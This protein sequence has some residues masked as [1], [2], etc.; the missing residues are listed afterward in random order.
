MRLCAALDTTPLIAILRRVT[1]AEAEAVGAALI[2]AGIL[3]IETPLNSPEPLRSIAV[4]ASRFGDVAA[5]GA[6]TVLNAAQVAQIADAGA[7]F[8]VSPNTDA[9]V[10]RA[11]LDR[12]LEPVPGV[13]TPSE[14]FAAI[15]AGASKLKLFPADSCGPDHLKALRAVLPS[16]V[17]VLAVGGVGAGEMKAWRAAGAA[18]FGLGASLYRPGDD[19][20][21]VKARA[22]DAVRALRAA[23]ASP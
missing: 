11:A 19:A 16:S 22:L 2:E 15:D 9:L 4:M 23:D 13:M 12:G 7:T 1:P 5:I 3:A 18:G 10:I 8:V 17:A 14:A 20:A 21:T 6:G